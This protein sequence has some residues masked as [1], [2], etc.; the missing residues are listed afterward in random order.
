MP[1][2]PLLG[3]ER[4][5]SLSRRRPS[6]CRRWRQYGR[7]TNEKPVFLRSRRAT[8]KIGRGAWIGGARILDCQARVARP[9]R[10]DG[11][12]PGAALRRGGKCGSLYRSAAYASRRSQTLLM[13]HRHR[14]QFATLRNTPARRIL[15]RSSFGRTTWPRRDQRVGLTTFFQNSRRER[16]R[17]PGAGSTYTHT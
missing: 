2:T 1:A 14:S 16:S 8:R 17:P 11:C 9:R 7:S 12:W 6:R 5:R 13:V 3:R 4:N 10:C 15:H